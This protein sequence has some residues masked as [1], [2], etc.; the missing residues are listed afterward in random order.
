M[1]TCS[2]FQGSGE[3]R[4][5]E[6]TKVIGRRGG[7]SRRQCQGLFATHCAYASV[8]AGVAVTLLH[9]QLTVDSSKTGQ[10][11][12]RVAALTCVH[13]GGAVQAGVMMCAEVEIWSKQWR[14]LEF[15]MR[16]LNVVELLN[17][18]GSKK[19]GTLVT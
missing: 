15:N 8:S 19:V 11:R 18:G 6:R 13:A 12:A 4:E 17:C 2:R 7:G 3:R 1:Y 5:P 10:A 16:K 14:Q 9:L